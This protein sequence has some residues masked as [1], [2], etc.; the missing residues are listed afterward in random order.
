MHQNLANYSAHSP[1]T[2]ASTYWGHSNLALNGR[3]NSTTYSVWQAN[4]SPVSSLQELTQVA[5]SH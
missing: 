4:K 2:A 3:N 1:D 5:R